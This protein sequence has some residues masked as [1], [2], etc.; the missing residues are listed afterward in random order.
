MAL[1]NVEA[2]SLPL[3]PP[4]VIP[5][6]PTRS[7][8]HPDIVCHTNWHSIISRLSWV[9]AEHV[10]T[11]NIGWLELT[12]SR[13]TIGVAVLLLSLMG[14]A[15]LYR[16]SVTPFPIPVIDRKTHIRTE[17][18]AALYCPFDNQPALA[19]KAMR[20]FFGPAHV[21]D[22]RVRSRLWAG[23]PPVQLSEMEI[24]RIRNDVHIG[25][26]VFEWEEALGRSK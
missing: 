25:F 15:E 26:S 21:V 20:L 2:A 7:K 17:K 16:R 10:S 6:E 1:P 13:I 8:P 23:K 4:R 3:N 11:T 14:Y 19:T 9:L 18:V 5:K 12:K 22:R 24:M